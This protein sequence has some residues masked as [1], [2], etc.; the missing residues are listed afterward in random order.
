MYALYS[1]S[2]TKKAVDL[3]KKEF[4]DGSKMAHK[5]T[6]KTKTSDKVEFE[7]NVSDKPDGDVKFTV[8]IDSSFKVGLK[9]TATKDSE[10]DTEFKLDSN[11]TIK[12]TL[13][14]GSGMDTAVLTGGV[15][16]ATEAFSVEGSFGI[17]D[18]ACVAKCNKDLKVD[19]VTLGTMGNTGA[20]A[21]FAFDCPGAECVKV[22]LQP[23]FSLFETYKKEG[24][25]NV[26]DKID[27][28]LNLNY[29]AAL[30]AKDYQIAVTG[31][32]ANLNKTATFAGVGLKGWF[33]YSDSLQCAVE[34]DMAGA[35]KMQKSMYQKAGKGDGSTSL[36]LG[37]DYKLADKTNF[38]GKLTMVKAADAKSAG[39]PVVDLALKTALEGK[40][41]ATT[42]V[43]F[44]GDKP[45][46]GFTVTID[47]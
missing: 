45:K 43:N 5:L 27:A 32:F 39:A 42:F 16:Y 29:S 1:K 8:P 44:G 28:V 9:A 38:K 3:N 41:T 46:F 24:D 6:M 2:F 17:Y 15:D 34:A 10:M 14:N 4:D 40:S 20:S 13:K 11:T 7:S 31:G 26:K 23:G 25:K 33:K 21:A 36:K 30:E 35:A 19:T 22:G 47:G 18:G 12:A 37:L